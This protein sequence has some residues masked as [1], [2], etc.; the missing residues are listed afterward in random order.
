MTDEPASYAG[1]SWVGRRASGF[2]RAYDVVSG[3]LICS[4]DQI[5]M[6]IDRDATSIISCV[7]NR[8]Y[9][10]AANIEQ[11]MLIAARVSCAAA[12]AV[13]LGIS[14]ASL[15]TNR[16][17]LHAAGLEV[18]GQ[19]IAITAPSGTGKSTLLWALLDQGATMASDDLMTLRLSDGDVLATPS[20]SVHAKLTK[21]ALVDRGTDNAGM[22]EVMP[23]YDEYWMPMP[24]AERVTAEQ[25]LQALFVL[26]P[27]PNWPIMQTSIDRIWAGDALVRLMEATQGLW[28]CHSAL[29]PYWMRG[30]YL[31]F[32]ESVP[33]Y[34]VR[35]N[36]TWNVIPRLIEQIN[37]TIKKQ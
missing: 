6:Y 17:P 4:A 5:V 26:A 7:G 13:N 22:H 14:I 2:L 16:I 23:G 10:Y 1:A 27:E 29:D 19:L 32:I 15:F 8:S 25:P 20:I 37:M 3:A 11:A 9:R 18:D 12:L 35:Y 36:R 24:E 33:I 34:L 31:G 30:F 28:S 21:S